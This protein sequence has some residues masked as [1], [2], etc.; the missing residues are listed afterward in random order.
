[1]NVSATGASSGF[2]TTYDFTN[3]TNAQFLQEIKSLREQGV[4]SDDQTALLT[5]DACGGDSLP[6]DGNPVSTS[7][8]LSDTTT[9]DFISVFQMQDD[10]MHS[11][12]RSV[13]TAVVDSIVQV[14]KSYQGR[15]VDD[16]SS[17][18]SMEV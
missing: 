12:P 9:R 5:I 2:G 8:A 13:G 10:W 18:V 11:N 4:L 16:S 3:V 1:M 15:P 14:L 17:N 6:I 7:Q